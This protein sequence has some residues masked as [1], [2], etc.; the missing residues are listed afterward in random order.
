[1]R[2]IYRVAYDLLLSRIDERLKALGLSERRA[3][4]LAGVG[5]NSIRHLRPPREHAPKPATL[6]KLATVL[7]VPPAYL[8]DAAAEVPV[9]PGGVTMETVF[10]RGAVQ[11]GE[12]RDAIEWPP[13]DWFTVQMPADPR[14]GS[15]TRFGLV[16]RGTSMDRL[17]PEGTIVLV[18]RFHDI[19]RPPRTGDRVVVL[20]RSTATGD[21]EATLKEY[22]LDA[23]G[24]HVLWPRSSDPEFQAPFILPPGEPPVADGGAQL[25]P[26]VFGG[27]PAHMAGEADVLISALVVGSYRPEVGV[28]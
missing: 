12:W 15:V 17:Y 1:M 28:L 9:G 10:V 22:E 3:C 13:S 4:D 27:S 7:G 11:G 16:V 25:P 5:V 2:H 19:G 23:Q 14:L 18:V 24:R 6:A 8:L 21:F 26:T 20:R